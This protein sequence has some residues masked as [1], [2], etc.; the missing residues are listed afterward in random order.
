MHPRLFA[1]SL[2]AAF[3][4]A[5]P[6]C[7]R[8]DSDA[9][10]FFNNIDVT[11]GSPVEDAVCFFCSV[12]LEGKASGD[13]VV[14][15]GNVRIDGQAQQDVVDFFGKV[16]ASND[17]SIG[18]DLV[19]IFGSVRLGDGV[20]V[21]GDLVTVFGAS[22]TPSSITVGGHHVVL[23]PLIFF[24]PLFILFLIVYLIVHAIRTSR[25]HAAAMPYPAPPIPPM[26][27]QQ[28]PPQR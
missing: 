14:F 1:L 5:A 6:A 27:P 9:V 24:A 2:F 23:S 11:P 26:S 13:I 17:S 10:Q 18:G 15:F 7:A 12:H 21:G 19:T 16:S 25:M 22:R 8:A 28:A 4:A 3:L 20:K